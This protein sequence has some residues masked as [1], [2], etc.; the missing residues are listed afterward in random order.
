MPRGQTGCHVFLSLIYQGCNK[1]TP[2]PFMDAGCNKHTPF[3]L[4][5]AACNNL[6]L[7]DKK[8]SRTGKKKLKS[9]PGPVFFNRDSINGKKKLKSHADSRNSMQ[10]HASQEK[11]LAARPPNP[12]KTPI[13]VQV[14]SKCFYSRFLAFVLRIS[15]A[16]H[17]CKPIL[18]AIARWLAAHQACDDSIR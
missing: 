6:A 17:D 9:L 18:E 16:D 3:P 15:L 5:G 13:N 7:R 2:F 11:K 4:M 10:Q 14:I 1:N 12:I 8:K